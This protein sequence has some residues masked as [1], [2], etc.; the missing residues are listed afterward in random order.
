MTSKVTVDAHAGW[1]I[2]VTM[3]NPKTNESRVEIVQPKTTQDF[4]VYDDRNLFIEE[5]KK[6]ET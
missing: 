3:T 1:P 5:M 6:E 2:R 4:Y